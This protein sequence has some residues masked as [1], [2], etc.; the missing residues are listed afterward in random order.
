MTDASGLAASD[1]LTPAALTGLLRLDATGAHPALRTV[2]AGLPVAGWSGT[3]DG[4]F[5]AAADRAAAG[6]VRAKTGTLTGVATLA[7][8]VHTSAG[9]LVVAAVMSEHRGPT[10]TAEAAL[11]AVFARLARCGCAGS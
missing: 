8:Y 5:R 11:D 6:D 10:E 3:L 9:R 2:I 1:R 7:G 4:R